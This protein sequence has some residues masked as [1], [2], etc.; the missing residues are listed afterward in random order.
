LEGEAMTKK[1]MSS[2][3]NQ[4]GLV[5]ADAKTLMTFFIFLFLVI[6]P[7]MPAYAAEEETDQQARWQFGVDFYLWMADI[8]GE[9]A[10]GDTIDVPFHTLLENL[11][12]A[13]MG[14]FHAR[15]GR[16]HFSTDV[17]YMKLEGDNS[18][19]VTVPGD[20][21]LKTDAKVKVQ[22]WVVS[23]A[24]GY[25]FIDTEK[26][27]TEFVAG[28]RYLWLKPELKL[29]ITG[30]LNSSS[31]NISE[32][33]DVWDGIVGIR[34]NVNLAK[35]WYIPYYADIGSG[36]SEYTWQAMAGVGYRINNMVDVVAV[37]R[38]LK[39]KFDDNKVI[40]NLDFGGPLVGLR[41]QF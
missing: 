40:D 10:S 15:N 27:R 7:V 39:W 24:V 31:K 25:S 8:G 35:D 5:K 17:I 12:F 37:Y 14:A 21:E 41:L 9:S 33:G 23:P 11:D 1:W 6:T 36:Q 22:A 38:Y 4:K 18:G 26:I 30:P 13:Y 16:W 19:T 34:G 32:S 29:K 2:T 28:A 3:K 20:I